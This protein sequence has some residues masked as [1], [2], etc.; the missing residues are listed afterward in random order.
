MARKTS[1]TTYLSMANDI[2]SIPNTDILLV[3]ENLLERG[4]VFYG[5]KKVTKYLQ[6]YGYI[7]NRKKVFRIMKENNL[8]NHT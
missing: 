3:I 1:K 6:R 5:Y 4:F 8:L 7:T 2:I